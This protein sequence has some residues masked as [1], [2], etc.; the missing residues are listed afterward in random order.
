MSD[1]R[2]GSPKGDGSDGSDKSR[3]GQQ[4]PG[5]AKIVDMRR[6]VPKSRVRDVVR[7]VAAE[8]SARVFFTAHAEERMNERGVTR[9]QV[10][11]CLKHGKM[12]RSD[13]KKSDQGNW[14][15]KLEVMSAG[16][17]VKVVAALDFDE[18]IGDYIVVITTYR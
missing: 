13:P 11:R 8:D 10:L 6:A 12:L 3:P 18:K 17:A 9:T 15:L 2:D 1:E 14:T 16:E 5:T 4:V 7:D